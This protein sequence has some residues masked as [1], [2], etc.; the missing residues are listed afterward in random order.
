[1]QKKDYWRDEMSEDDAR[2][3]LGS[4][5]FDWALD[6]GVGYCAGRA[7]GYWYANEPE[8]YAAYR[9]AERIARASA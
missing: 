8:H 1:M 6:K 9:T 5:H 3:L 2:N 7:S 4:D